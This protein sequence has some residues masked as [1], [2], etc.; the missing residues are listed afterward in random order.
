MRFGNM[1]GY[2]YL[3][4]RIFDSFLA[5]GI[6]SYIDERKSVDMDNQFIEITHEY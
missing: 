3:S 1:K 2:F 4:Y 5:D 6:L